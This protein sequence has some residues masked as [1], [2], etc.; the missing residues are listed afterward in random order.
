VTVRP[1]ILGAAI[2]DDG[3]A[4]ILPDDWQRRVTG[5]LVGKVAVAADVEGERPTHNGQ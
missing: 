4:P 3:C 1:A 2:R 5:K